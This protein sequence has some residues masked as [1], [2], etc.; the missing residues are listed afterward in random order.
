MTEDNN[1]VKPVRH[2]NWQEWDMLN[3][4]P[5]VHNHMYDILWPNGKKEQVTIKVKRLRVPTYDWGH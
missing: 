2:V 4:V 3:G 1:Y 5:F